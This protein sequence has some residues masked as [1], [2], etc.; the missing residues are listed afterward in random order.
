MR[1][2]LLIAALCVSAFSFSQLTAPTLSL[3]LDQVL[4]GKGTI[5]VELLA[6]II[7]EKQEELKK[8]IIE[9]EIL[10]PVFN[11]SSFTARNYVFASVDNLMNE[12]DKNVLKKQLM[13]ETSNFAVIYAIAELYLQSAFKTQDTLYFPGI[14][15]NENDLTDLIDEYKYRWNLQSAMYKTKNFTYESRDTIKVKEG[16]CT[17]EEKSSIKFNDALVDCVLQAVLDNEKLMQ[18]GF[19]NGAFYFN[20]D[21]YWSGSAYFRID[22]IVHRESLYNKV[23]EFVND[24]SKYYDGFKIIEEILR[25]NSGENAEARFKKEVNNFNQVLNIKRNKELLARQKQIQDALSTEDLRKVI[26]SD[27]KQTYLQIKQVKKS[28]HDTIIAFNI[29]FESINPEWLNNFLGGG[30]ASIEK[31]MNKIKISKKEK[32]ILMTQLNK[33][34]YTSLDSIEYPKANE[35]TKKQIENIYKFYSFIYSAKELSD[36][37]AG[38]EEYKADE[39]TKLKNELT[40]LNNKLSELG[41]YLVDSLPEIIQLINDSLIQLSKDSN[42]YTDT[43]MFSEIQNLL[44]RFYYLKYHEYDIKNLEYI[45]HLRESVI[46]DIAFLNLRTRGKLKDILEQVEYLGYFLEN[47]VKGPINDALFG[48]DTINTSALFREVFSNGDESH[49][50]SFLSIVEFFQRLDQLDHAETYY[51]LL[52]QLSYAGEHI[53]NRDVANAINLIT[54]SVEKY[55]DFNQDV[56]MIDI[57]VEN[58]IL[59]LLEKYGDR[60]R[61]RMSLHLTLGLNNAFAIDDEALKNSNAENINTFSF[62]SEKIGFRINIFDFKLK[63][64]YEIGEKR[65]YSQNSFKREVYN[66]NTEPLLSNIH[67]LGYGSGLL[68][69]IADLGTTKDINAIFLGAGFGATFYNNLNFNVSAL[70]PMYFEEQFPGW[71]LNVGFDVHFAEYIRALNKK[72]QAQKKAEFE[73]KEK[74]LEILREENTSVVVNKPVTKTKSRSVFG[75]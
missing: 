43:S 33:I 50:E 29:P 46:P 25:E 48:K 27:L 67:F 74:E 70:K 52:E 44:D 15:K 59:A 66:Y 58:I 5:D 61:N 55:T 24:I 72:R 3:G 41:E 63:H 22:N 8:R 13:I 60:D 75:L 10:E 39:L 45:H 42:W 14:F 7:T 54:Q 56:D 53:D 26:T 37:L 21:Q 32:E 30:D 64:A 69:N 40:D 17:K 28:I 1:A 18:R 31:T 71:A 73:L 38:L 9:K 57:D 23:S 11:N 20:L 35:E 2:L 4:F 16:L 34:N 36:K 62:A 19:L 12:K 6:E 47:E 51:Y 49:Y 68:Y 65:P